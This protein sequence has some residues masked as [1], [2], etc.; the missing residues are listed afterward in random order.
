MSGASRDPHN[1]PQVLLGAVCKQCQLGWYLGF[2]FTKRVWPV[3]HP[4]LPEGSGPWL[5]FTSSRQPGSPSRPGARGSARPRSY[6]GSSPSLCKPVEGFYV[7]RMSRVAVN[8]GLS[9][10]RR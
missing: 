7:T 8:H 6:P 10:A 4:E 2:E 1:R 9:G 5:P 3:G